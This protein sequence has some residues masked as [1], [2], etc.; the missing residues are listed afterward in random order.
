MVENTENNNGTLPVKKKPVYKGNT[1]IAVAHSFRNKILNY[2]IEAETKHPTFE[3]ILEWRNSE[4]LIGNEDYDRLPG[5][6]RSELLGYFNGLMDLL[7][8]K[9][10][11]T[12]VFRNKRYEAHSGL[13]REI[14]ESYTGPEISPYKEVDH[15]RS[16][17]CYLT[18]Q[19][20]LPFREADRQKDIANKTETGYTITEA[21][22]L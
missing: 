14:R 12:H 20:L 18:P 7:Q 16:D 22:G 13:W 8:R 19:G 5:Y 11:W 15:E 1:L 4:I 17:H 10:V 21:L 3:A 2:F 9:L 6:I